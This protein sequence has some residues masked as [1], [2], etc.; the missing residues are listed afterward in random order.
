M[1]KIV[2]NFI[3]CLMGILPCGAYSANP[4]KALPTY[5]VG[6]FAQGGVIFWLDPSRQHGLVCAIENQSTGAAWLV[7]LS[8]LEIGAFADGIWMGAPNTKF[9]NDF[10]EEYDVVGTFAPKLCGDYRGGAY[11]DWYLPS[12]L[13]WALLYEMTTLVNSVSVAHGGTAINLIG[14]YWTSTEKDVSNSYAE[15]YLEGKPV[16][17]AKSTLCYVRAIRAF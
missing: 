13:E 10:I 17:T 9:L 12:A 14:S 15:S 2:W 1:K 7:A 8:P 6:D 5:S 3:F 4:A 11:S 16:S